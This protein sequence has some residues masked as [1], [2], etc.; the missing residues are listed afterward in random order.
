MIVLFS[1][2]TKIPGEDKEDFQAKPCQNHLSRETLD[3]TCLIGIHGI[4]PFPS[5]L[6]VMFLCRVTVFK[7]TAPTCS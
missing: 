3:L 5:F 4:G 7:E 1:F 2:C 6:F